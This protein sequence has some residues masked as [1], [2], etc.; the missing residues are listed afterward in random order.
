MRG[1]RIAFRAHVATSRPAE[2]L[3]ISATNPLPWSVSAPGA[4]VLRA[5]RGL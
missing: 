3:P 2:I 1:Y 5:T 4:I